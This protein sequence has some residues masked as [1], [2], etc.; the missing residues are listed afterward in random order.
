MLEQLEQRLP[1]N[2]QEQRRLAFASIT[3]SRRTG[4]PGEPEAR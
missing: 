3:P 1:A 4:M 2:W